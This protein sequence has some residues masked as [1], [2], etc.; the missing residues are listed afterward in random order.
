VLT[1]TVQ[2]ES[3]K[4]EQPLTAVLEPVWNFPPTHLAAPS[5][6]IHVWRASLDSPAQY[7]EPLMCVLSDAEHIRARHFYF[8][9]DR[10][11]FIAGRGLLRIILGRYL[12]ISPDRLQLYY[13][14]AGKPALSASQARQ[15]IEFSLSHSRGLILYAV[16]CNRRIGIDVE[17]AR[18]IANTDHIAKRIFAPREYAVFRA[19]PLEER[20]A[21][22]FRGWTRKEAYLKACGEGLSRGL[23]R[24]DVSSAPFEPA[25]RLGIQ[26]D[27]Q[28]ASPWSLQELA[29]APGYVAAVASEGENAPPLSCLQWPEWL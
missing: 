13:G 1:P 7:V 23:D 16:T 18:T 14:V 27:P 29:P 15:G 11:R 4:P 10:K 6:M 22:F 17:H 19:L 8:E 28:A 2:Q 21:A 3:P 5:N 20:Q 25:R 12:A 24:I 9:R 26:G